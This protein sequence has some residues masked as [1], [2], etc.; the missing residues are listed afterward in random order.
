MLCLSLCVSD[1]E[2]APGGGRAPDAVPSSDVCSEAADRAVGAGVERQVGLP[3]LLSSATI[4]PC[5]A[6]ASISAC[7]LLLPAVLVEC[8]ES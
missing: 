3:L 8:G 1:G 2:A 4:L 6:G 5:A 7:L